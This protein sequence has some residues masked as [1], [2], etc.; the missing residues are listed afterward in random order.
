M[1]L[2]E[3]L[4]RADSR[5]FTYLRRPTESA[6]EYLRRVAQWDGPGFGEIAAVDVQAAL[7]EF[8]AQG[9]AAG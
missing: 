7:R 1:G 2:R 3:R 8:F 6:E 5:V 4:R 9:D